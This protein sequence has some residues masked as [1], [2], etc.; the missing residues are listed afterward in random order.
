LLFVSVCD[1]FVEN[2]TGSVA[3]VDWHH[4]RHLVSRHSAVLLQGN[5]LRKI[6]RAWRRRCKSAAYL[7][8]GCREAATCR[9]VVVLL[10]RPKMSIFA[11]QRQLVALTAIVK[12]RTGSGG[13]RQVQE[14]L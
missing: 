8:R 10:K 5:M 13:S 11:L 3:G 9:Y 2:S 1:T 12:V 6:R 4:W 7:P 14:E